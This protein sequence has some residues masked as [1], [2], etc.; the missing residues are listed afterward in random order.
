MPAA[1]LTYLIDLEAI[2]SDLI[3][4]AHR[5]WCLFGPKKSAAGESGAWNVRFARRLAFTSPLG[6]GQARKLAL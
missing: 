6:R 5:I 3:A 1:E 2:K 4:R